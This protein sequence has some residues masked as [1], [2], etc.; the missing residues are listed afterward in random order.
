MAQGFDP[1]LTQTYSGQLRRIVNKDGTFNVRHVGGQYHLY[2]HIVSL[3]WKKFFLLAIC[4]FL[5]TNGVFASLYM[6]IGVENLSGGDPQMSP[7][8]NAFF[9]STQ[10]LTTVGYGHISPRGYLVSSVAAL[11]GMLGL[12]GFAVITGLLYGRISRPSARIV[13]S[14]RMLVAP[15]E[16]A[17]SLQFRIANARTNVL[18]DIEANMVLMTVDT[19]PDGKMKRKYAELPLERN[20]VHLFPL[21]WTVVH[22]IVESSPLWGKTAA[23]ITALQ[24]EVLILI[25]CFDD[26]FSQTVNSL[27]S[28]RHEEIVWNSRFEP[29]FYFDER[30]DMVL[31]LDRLN[32]WRRAE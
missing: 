21:S 15:Y 17:T 23:E 2:L 5:F 10:T 14:D 6:S 24:A 7:L 3:S 26:T 25:R 9:F 31:Q 11:E 1:G 28:Y 29:A 20:H 22:P 27:H 4:C 16:G 13:F 32:A 18:M 12:M 8:A 30:G 19:D